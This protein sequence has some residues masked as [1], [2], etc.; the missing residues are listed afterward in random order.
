MS[1]CADVTGRN[2]ARFATIEAGRGGE[3]RPTGGPGGGG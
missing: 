3:R 1:N 2:P